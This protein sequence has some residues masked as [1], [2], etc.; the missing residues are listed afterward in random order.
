MKITIQLP[1]H[2]ANRRRNNNEKLEK[3]SK[4]DSN[5]RDGQTYGNQSPLAPVLQEQRSCGIEECRRREQRSCHPRLE[6]K[7]DRSTLEDPAD[8]PNP[9]LEPSPQS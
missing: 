7:F 8:A 2:G 9:L 3:R 6:R 1:T 4:S 5:V